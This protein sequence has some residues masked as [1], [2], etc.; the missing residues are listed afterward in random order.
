MIGSSVCSET[1]PNLQGLCSNVLF[2]LCGY[3]EPQLNMVSAIKKIKFKLI[4]W[5]AFCIMNP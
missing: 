1:F 2:L 5:A 4:F 3:D